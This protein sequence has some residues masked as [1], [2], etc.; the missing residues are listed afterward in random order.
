MTTMIAAALISLLTQGISPQILIV[1]DDGLGSYV[2][3][4]V[5][6]ALPFAAPGSLILIRPGSYPAATITGQSVNLLGLNDA[7]GAA[8]RL[9]GLTLQGINADKTSLRNLRIES[10]STGFLRVQS[11][12]ASIM[13]E[14]V[15]ADRLEAFN[16]SALGL[17]DVSIT[18]G[19]SA[20]QSRVDAYDSSF[21][22]FQASGTGVQLTQSAAFFSGCS[23]QGGAGLSGITVGGLICT[24]GQ[25]GGPALAL[26]QSTAVRLDTELKGGSGG[27][28]GLAFPYMTCSNGPNGA[29]VLGGGLTTLPNPAAP[30]RLDAN[31][32]VVEGQ[33]LP[34]EL[35]GAPGEHTFLFLAPGLAP[36]TLPTWNGTLLLQVPGATLIPTGILPASGELSLSFTLNLPA[37][38]V[39]VEL[40]VQPLFVHPS[41]LGPNYLG[42]AS[43]VRF[44]DDLVP[45]QDCDGNQ[46]PDSMDLAQGSGDCD[47]NGQ[48]DICEIL[49]GAA[50]DC[51][52]NGIIDACDVAAGAADID[53]NLV[54]DSCQQKVRVPQDYP[55]IKAAANAASNGA[56]ILIDSGTYVGPNNRIIAA[57]Y[58][59]LSFV[60]VNGPASTIVDLQSAGIF[61]WFSKCTL[62]NTVKGLTFLR[63]AE[64]WGTGAVRSSHSETCRVQ[65][66]VFSGCTGGAITASTGN[67]LEI[68]R[69]QFL[70]NSVAI[71][72]GG[73][74]NVQEISE[75]LVENCIFARNY[76]NTYHDS[77]GGGAIHIASLPPNPMTMHRIRNCLFYENGTNFYGGAIR[78]RG[79][80][81]EISGCTFANNDD[82]I[83]SSVHLS[84]ALSAQVE[85]SILVA[86]AGSTAA[87]LTLPA[88]SSLS[89]SL[90]SSG[91]LPGP[92]V[93]T[94]DPQFL[95]TALLDF[96]L[97]PG[98]PCIDS[99][100]PNYLPL[101]G[102]VDLA[103]QPRLQGAA[104][105]IG[106]YEQ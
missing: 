59:S 48:L 28:A 60:G 24:N 97:A 74:I 49:S 17:V 70:N 6:A 44:I 5:D 29:Q 105:D 10:S 90:L 103:G 100:N 67:S 91:L 58:K 62:P 75:V 92:G 13:L 9:A 64:Y 26:S 86:P 3:P 101:P 56:I 31:L 21:Q 19:T 35:K 98:S 15:W 25:P 79:S 95:S 30:H 32:P 78:G 77:Q 65:D 16:S 46:V 34:L 42:G 73:A 57:F 76:S 27:P 4:D 11:C 7:L 68:S 94:G 99:G 38:V 84:D 39:G 89:Y 87:V 85:N 36:L 55:N 8:P 23:L 47:Q 61:V 63:G 71:G 43:L 88:N 81:V 82:L 33:A 40:P 45:L 102:E 22:N 93:L 37:G 50:A 12:Q 106:C 66:C 20:T 52:Q 54:P 69:C 14:D 1:D 2:Y 51:N 41:G 83:G 96:R 104:V 72:P 53:G 18:W 80:R